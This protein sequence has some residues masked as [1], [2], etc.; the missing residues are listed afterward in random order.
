MRLGCAVRILGRRGIRAYDARRL[1]RAPHLSLSLAHLHD[2]LAYLDAADIRMYRMASEIAPALAYPSHPH[3]RSQIEE[4]VDQLQMLGLRARQQ[5]VRLSFHAPSYVQL[6]AQDSEIVD[7]SFAA[8]DLLATLLD[9]MQLDADA[10]IVVHVGGLYGDVE[11]A[12]GRWVMRWDRL[13]DAVRR[14]LVLEHED[15]GATLGMALRIHAATGVPVVF[16]HLHWCLNNPDGWPM[17]EAL[18]AALHTWPIDRTPK[19]HFSSPRT[20]LQAVEQIDTTTGRARWRL[21]PPRSGHHSDFVNAWQF[22]DLVR[23]A[24]HL[25][26]FDVMLEAKAGDLALLRLRQDL[27]RYVTDVAAWLE[28]RNRSGIREGS[29][30]VLYMPVWHRIVSQRVNR[31]R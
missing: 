16:D 19:I 3:L 12:L 26:D 9:T 31:C 24:A 15:D 10:V 28:H 30:A 2:V 8:L 22:A 18:A 23:T 14:R 1:D 5:R 11:G 17:H 4:C 29:G 27:D 13:S 6:A 7:R 25:R 20:E 21:R